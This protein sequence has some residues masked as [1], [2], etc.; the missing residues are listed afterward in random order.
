MIIIN[1]KIDGVA[2]YKIPCKGVDLYEQQGK[3]TKSYKADQETT[4]SSNTI[5][6]LSHS[7]LT[8]IN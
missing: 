3:L 4:P 8:R 2:R 5:N 6:W 7:T 1:P